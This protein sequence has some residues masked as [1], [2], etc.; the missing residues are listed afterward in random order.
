MIGIVPV[1]SPSISSSATCQP[2]RPGI[3]TSRRITSGSSLRAFSSPVGPS[4]ASSTS[5]PSA[6]RFTRQRS[7]IGASSSI[8]STLVIG[9]A[10]VVGALIY[11]RSACC[12]FALAQDRLPGK[13]QREQERRA[14]ARTGSNPDAAA[15]RR[16]QLLGDEEAEVGP[17]ATEVA[18]RALGAVEL[19]EDPAQLGLGDADAFVLDA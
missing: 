7:R 18:T 11:T 14:L 15:H 16:E 3:I 12:S 19:R 2:S 4:L 17:A 8:T 1:R 10:L 6:S 5:I 13:G 9:P